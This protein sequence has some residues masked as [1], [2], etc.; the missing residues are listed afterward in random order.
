[1][2]EEKKIVALEEIPGLGEKKA[3]QLREEL[4]IENSDELEQALYSGEVAE[5]SGFGAKTIEALK[6]AIDS[7]NDEDEEEEI[8]ELVIPEKEEEP[9]E[10]VSS[11]VRPIIV[12]NRFVDRLFEERSARAENAYP[13]VRVTADKHYI[14]ENRMNFLFSLVMRML[15]PGGIAQFPESFFNDFPN[16]EKKEGYW[17]ITKGE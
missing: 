12:D 16:A 2:A 13:L 6:E 7:L 14:R 3:E 5:L 17:N 4:G 8:V 9:K 11:S 1:M 10:T 15:T